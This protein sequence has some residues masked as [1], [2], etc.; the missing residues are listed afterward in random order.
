MQSGLESLTAFHN[1]YYDSRTGR[2]AGR[3]ILNNLTTI[4]AEKSGITVTKF[5]H[6]WPQ[7]SVIARINGNASGPVTILGCHL[8]S[9]NKDDPSEGRAPGA[10][11]VRFISRS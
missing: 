7:Y 2:R 4:A 3:L 10:D 11:D 8:D 1:R 6:S 5:M 9:I